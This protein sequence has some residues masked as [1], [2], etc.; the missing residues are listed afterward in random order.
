MGRYDWYT[1]ATASVTNIDEYTARV[2]VNCYFTNNAWNYH[3]YMYGYTS[4]DGGS[5]VCVM[6]RTNVDTRGADQN[7]GTVWLG[8][9]DYYFSRK[10]KGYDVS[11]SARIYSDGGYANGDKRSGTGW[12]HIDARPYKAFG[13]PS[14]KISDKS[15][16]YGSKITLSWA[17]SATQGNANFERFEVT[18]GMGKRLV[19][20]SA[21]SLTSTPSAIL[22]EYGKDHYYNTVSAPNKKK[23]WVYYAVREVHEWYGSYPASDWVWIGVEVKSGTVAIFD[24]AGKKVVGLLTMYD[25]SGSKRQTMISAYDSAGK[26]HDTQ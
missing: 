20:G 9:H 2:T 24:A 23:G 17:K 5:D 10:N 18:D 4:C 3:M 26:R 15:I 22:D 6:G 11:Y 14:V 12:V 1:Q 7:G 25:S 19:S 13:N 21:T 8:S 16:P